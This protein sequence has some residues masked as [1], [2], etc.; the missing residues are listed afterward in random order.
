MDADDADVGQRGRGQ[1][2][3]EAGEL[4]DGAGLAREA[5]EVAEAVVVG[6][7]E[8]GVRVEPA[9]ERLDVG[10]PDLDVGEDADGR[11]RGAEVDRDELDPV[12]VAVDL[13]GEVDL[14]AVA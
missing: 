11:A 9:L 5:V 7:E 4:T 13:G 8:Q 2:L 10:A 12:A 3:G 6:D 14:A 1:V